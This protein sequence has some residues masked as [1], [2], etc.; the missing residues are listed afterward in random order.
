MQISQYVKQ[1]P[2]G[3]ELADSCCYG[4][5]DANFDRFAAV[6]GDSHRFDPGGA[7]SMHYWY[8]ETPRGRA[9]VRDFHTLPDGLLA[10]VSADIR[11]TL[12]LARFLRHANLKVNLYQE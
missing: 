5:V 4:T 2:Q 3:Y 1:H 9:C 6:C 7:H 8:F 10:I 11:A 12:W